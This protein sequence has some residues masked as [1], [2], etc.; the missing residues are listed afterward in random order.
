MVERPILKKF[1]CEIQTVGMEYA[2]AKEA[3]PA[4]VALLPVRRFL[5]DKITSAAMATP[6]T[7]ICST[8]A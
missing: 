4:V 8:V 5:Q 6:S 1:D 7:F 2:D 3:R